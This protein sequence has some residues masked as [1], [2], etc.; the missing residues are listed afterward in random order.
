MVRANG[1][2]LPGEY[3]YD[4]KDHLWVRIEGDNVRIGLDMLGQK[5]AGDVKHLRF[6]P[7]GTV[8]AKKRMFGSIEAG[9]Y[10]GPLRAPVGGTIL[11]FNQKA[12]ETPGIVN[13]DS[14]GEG[15]FVVLA[16]SDLEGDLADLVHGDQEVSDWLEKEIAYYKEQG[17]LTDDHEED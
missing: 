15:W 1:Y 11:E 14:Y 9:K 7:V 16:P 3:Y 13:E 2:E 6:K 10:V 8:V 5:S 17:L 12:L 4:R